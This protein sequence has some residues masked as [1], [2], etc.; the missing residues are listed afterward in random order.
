MTTQLRLK[1]E[2]GKKVKEIAKYKERSFN[3]QIEYILK[4]YIADYEKINGKI[5][6]EKD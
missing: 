3:Q 6:V 2:I 1:D 4:L 5:E